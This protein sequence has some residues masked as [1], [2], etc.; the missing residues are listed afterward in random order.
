MHLLRDGGTGAQVVRFLVARAES[1]LRMLLRRTEELE[2]IAKA[3]E[4]LSSG[5]VSGNADKHLPGLVQIK[6]SVSFM[7]VQASSTSPVQARVAEFLR[8]KGS[9]INSRVLSALSVRVAED[10]FVKVKKMIKVPA[11][12]P[13]FRHTHCFRVFSCVMASCSAFSCGA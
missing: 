3:I 1:V 6:K 12:H 10:P 13:G 5:D 11:A 2:A 9:A 8:Q 4:I 7:Q